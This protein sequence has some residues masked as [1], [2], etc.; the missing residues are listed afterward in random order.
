MCVSAVVRREQVRTSHVGLLV[1]IYCRLIN[2]NLLYVPCH[3]RCDALFTMNSF[4]QFKGSDD[5]DIVRTT[6]N[7][8]NH[9]YVYY[10]DI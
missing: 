1:V 2:G 5:I 8:E 10:A 6:V 7:N 9:V 3:V 4:Q